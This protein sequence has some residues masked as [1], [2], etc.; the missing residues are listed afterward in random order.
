MDENYA[1]NTEA[2]E[3]LISRCTTAGEVV[4]ERGTLH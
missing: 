3:K 1:Y 2:Y 4:T